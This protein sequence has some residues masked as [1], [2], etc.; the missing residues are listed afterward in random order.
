[1]PGAFPECGHT[2]RQLHS[3]LCRSIG[4]V[5]VGS[6]S[7]RVPLLVRRCFCNHFSCRRTTFAEPF[8]H[9]VRQ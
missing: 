2:S 5:P 9:R 3:Q 7:A 4:G 1:M 8:P 6:R